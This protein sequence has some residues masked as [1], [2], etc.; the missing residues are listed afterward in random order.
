MARRKNT[1]RR[2]T[3]ESIFPDLGL[4]NEMNMIV[5]PQENT[6][7]SA[8]DAETETTS[9]LD[10]IV[11]LQINTRPTEDAETETTT[12]AAGAH[13]ETS[14]AHTESS[15][16]E[17]LPNSTSIEV[18]A[19]LQIDNPADVGDFN[20]ETEVTSTLDSDRTNSE[21]NENFP[22]PKSAGHLNQAFILNSI[23]DK[24]ELC[25]IKLKDLCDTY[26][27]HQ[28]LL[29]LG[30]LRYGTD[31]DG[32][33]D[34]SFFV[35]IG[36]K[37][38]YNSVLSVSS[39]K[40]DNK[41]ESL[42]IEK[43]FTY[44][45]LFVS[46]LNEIFIQDNLDILNKTY[47]KDN[48]LTVSLFYRETTRYPK[49]PKKLKLIDHLIG[50]ASIALDE[51]PSCLLVWLGIV[52]KFPCKKPNVSCK[53]K[54]DEIRGALNIGT[55]F[56]CTMQWIKSVTVGRWTPVTC[57]VYARTLKGPLNFYKKLYFNKLNM[58][59]DL[60]HLQ[61][62][63]RRQHIID[64]DVTLEWH[65]LLF[66]LQY[67]TM[68]E[69]TNMPDGNECI[70]T[71]FYRA[72]YFFLFQ[73]TKYSFLSSE[74]VP[75]L[76][77]YFDNHEL[78]ES[79]VVEITKELED[80]RSNNLETPELIVD[81]EV[82]NALLQSNANQSL[83]TLNFYA[84]ANDINE[85][86]YL[87]LLAS[88]VFYGS[89]AYHYIIRQFF[90]FIFRSISK[91]RSTHPFFNMVM[92]TFVELIIERTYR[93]L[94]YGVKDLIAINGLPSNIEE[95]QNDRGR[96]LRIY[97]NKL[98]SLYSE[99]FLKKRFKGDESD[100]LFLKT[101]LNYNLS[102]VNIF[103]ND[104]TPFAANYTR[105]FNI[106]VRPSDDILQRSLGFINPFITYL[107][108]IIELT[109]NTE[110]Q[111]CWLVRTYVNQFYIM[112]LSTDL[113]EERIIRFPK[114]I[115]GSELLTV[116][117]DE[118]ESLYFSSPNKKIP[119]QDNDKFDSTLDLI[120]TRVEEESMNDDIGK[121]YNLYIKQRKWKN[122]RKRF[123]I[124]GGRI[125]DNDPKHLRIGPMFDIGD[126][127]NARINQDMVM[128]ITRILDPWKEVFNSRSSAIRD[129]LPYYEIITFRKETWLSDYV[130]EAFFEILNDPLMNFPL[131]TWIVSSREFDWL[132]Q[133]QKSIQNFIKAL[134]KECTK[135]LLYLHI[136]DH[137]MTVE[138]EIPTYQSK[139]VLVYISDSLG[140]DFPLDDIAEEIRM[141]NVDLLIASINPLLPIT[142]LKATDVILQENTYDCGVCCNQRAYFIKRFNHPS[143]IPTDYIYLKN[144]VNF[145]IFM[146]AE[147]LKYNR[148]DI[149]KLVYFYNPNHQPVDWNLLKN[150]ENI[151]S[152][153]Y[154]EE[155]HDHDEANDEDKS[156]NDDMTFNEVLDALST[157]DQEPFEKKKDTLENI[158]NDISDN[159][160]TGIDSKENADNAMVNEEQSVP[161]E[162]IPATS[163]HGNL[164]YEKE[165]H[166]PK[167]F[168][169]N[170]TSGKVLKP[171]MNDTESEEEVGS[172]NETESDE[173]TENDDE[174]EK[175]SSVSS[176]K[177][178]DSDEE[179]GE[180]NDS[181]YIENEQV[182]S[183][184]NSP[185]I[186]QY[187]I[188]RKLSSNPTAPI[189]SNSKRRK[190]TSKQQNQ[191]K[192]ASA[193][194]NIDHQ[195]TKKVYG[196]E[197]TKK[198]DKLSEKKDE[199]LEK[200]ELKKK[201]AERKVKLT[202]IRNEIDRWEQW[203]EV[204]RKSLEVDLFDDNPN[205]FIDQ[206]VPQEEQAEL[207]Y[208]I[209]RLKTKMYAP[210]QLSFENA[211]AAASSAFFTATGVA[212]ERHKN[213]IKL[214]KE[215]GNDKTTTLYKT[216]KKDVIELAERKKF[217]QYQVQTIT[218]LL[219]FDAVYG[220]RSKEGK[221]RRK[222][223]Y[224]IAKLPDDTL[225]EKLVTKDW[226]EKHVEKDFLNKFYQ[227]ENERG[228]ILFL[229]E[230][231]DEKLV[232]DSNELRQLL[233]DKAVPPVYQYKMDG[234]D[235]KIH[236]IR[237]AV[238]FQNPYKKMIVRNMDWAIMTEK[239]S[240]NKLH[241]ES[242]PWAN[243]DEKGNKV[244]I[245][246]DCRDSLL[247]AALGEVTFELI[248]SVLRP[249]WE[250]EYS[251][252]GRPHLKP[253]FI[254]DDNPHFEF[255]P[256]SE[257]FI[258]KYDRSSGS[259]LSVRPPVFK[260]DF[261]GIFSH[262]QYYYFDMREISMDYFVNVNTR[263]ISGIYYDAV[264]KLFT[265]L[266]KFREKGR[267]K[268]KKVELDTR[269]V[270]T[271]IN[272]AVIDAAIKKSK[273]DDKQFV[274]LPIGL[275]K[276]IQTS[277]EIKKNP[278]IAYP[279]Y[280][281]DTCV[282]SSLSSA[283]YF[284]QYEDTAY[285]IDVF[286]KKLLTDMFDESFENLMG[287]I[288]QHIHEDEYYKMFRS[289]CQV[290]KIINC[291]SFDL[292]K[293]S[294][295]RENVLFHVVVISK[296]GGENHA[297]CV[298]KNWIFDGNYTNA[299]P[300]SQESLNKSCDSVFEGIACGYKYTFA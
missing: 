258:D 262:R 221:T 298:V 171:N 153:E 15:T 82:V 265:G 44:Q 56:I 208:D 180:E 88:K 95:I 11:P 249:T 215:V 38:A 120:L 129:K 116:L 270:H 227:A 108:Q 218:E 13:T 110:M 241:P 96:I 48:I 7:P 133:S 84:D 229:Q 85:A 122:F 54:L 92:P 90:Y 117:T 68:F 43:S 103:T 157:I 290:R 119:T 152:S 176:H 264:T 269:W 105:K 113:N 77:E 255:V 2:N 287:R 280:G 173:E 175:K 243:T 271:N 39:T 256:N 135:I 1:S 150:N 209:D 125:K 137:Y 296:D 53:D 166:H 58:D 240:S 213:A 225:K 248:K 74:I 156:E 40:K 52:A 41:N 5:P 177:D 42:Y 98:L 247:K 47:S 36:T 275:G 259:L 10:M 257:R 190:L 169:R 104:T 31:N 155:D 124:K 102:I 278:I 242:G 276:P 128:P 114:C 216:R 194:T 288:T 293:E 62:L 151:E 211:Q 226:I 181:D 138:I 9:E 3:R 23:I 109:T 245:Y 179:K 59:H 165:S 27:K 55:F 235:D 148:P 223:Y 210:Q 212:E 281:E 260:R 146:L 66:P 266:E 97:Y 22:L 186:G 222:E 143:M 163:L 149:S 263:Q 189:H 18:S 65:A 200:A 254:F 73:P 25:F 140:E 28:N 139:E 238:T 111:S 219:P 191:K 170:Y 118:K 130:T 78:N 69:L 14:D 145:R 174:E 291:P 284:L 272:K 80:S 147:I 75:F 162:N 292:I 300:L 100:I 159:K 83:K 297:I 19:T 204:P 195:T 144:T 99:S 232:K 192:K 121:I 37:N 33:E 93:N 107:S 285:K 207:N 17:P 250:A 196:R 45:T 187:R 72:N 252:Q 283:L 274:K 217:L 142:Y 231:A 46:F 282:F 224:V 94:G 273:S 127:A 299:L 79:T 286:K 251:H 202:N 201:E 26:F 206:K 268:F 141:A 203:T 87:F 76:M 115:G 234:D 230:D 239:H 131:T 154:N 134:P 4:V 228:W 295:A 172:H 182:E 199:R 101:F 261:C 279:Q 220:L 132:V 193:R 184:E 136:H 61:Y 183:K 214:L 294:K 20:L 51:Y 34:Y 64:D 6:R 60:I 277:K 244:H 236:C 32:I 158:E 167:T 246:W 57:Q 35:C 86:G 29:Q 8:E 21:D 126:Y 198:K 91:L 89:A 253:N 30:D 164:E 237:V 161:Q 178:Y 233:Q 205:Y 197:R 160:S 70:R 12:M 24:E 50:A 123:K 81:S 112:T 16:T 71:I 267:H 185:S 289:K 63:R 168:I 106:Q 67:L 188:K 49:Q